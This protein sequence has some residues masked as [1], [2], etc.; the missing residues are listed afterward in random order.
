[1]KN[2]YDHIAGMYD[3]LSRLVYGRAQ[4]QVQLD[5]LPYIKPGSR[6]LIVGGGSGWILEEIATR[7]AS[8][9]EI[10]YV[11]I[12]IRML[13]LS[14][15][16]HYGKNKVTFIHGAIEDTTLTGDFDTVITAFLFDNFA[17][18]RVTTVFNLLN[19][20]LK[21]SGIW[22]FAD[23]VLENGHAGLWK[24]IILKLMYTFFRLICHVEAKHLVNMSP[25][26]K[27]YEPLASSVKYFG[28]IKGI[29]YQ[30]S[31]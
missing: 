2:N 13:R 23:F 5:L 24:K 11:E 10:V 4:V 1:M 19:A 15:K 29:A 22:L 27:N 28:F 14:K 30:K 25:F 3:F 6:I 9:L 12:S 21:P 31:C 26:F 7:H 16:R 18:K 8:G 17:E 20:Q